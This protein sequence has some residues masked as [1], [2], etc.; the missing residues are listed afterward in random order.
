MSDRLRLRS[1]LHLGEHIAVTE[2]VAEPS[3]SSVETSDLCRAV[4]GT[5][6]SPARQVP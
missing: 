2:E 6:A 4:A 1:P 3:R 5:E